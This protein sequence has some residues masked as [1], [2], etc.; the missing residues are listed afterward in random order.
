MKRVLGYVLAVMGVF[1]SCDSRK[2]W[3]ELNSPDPDLVVV[4]NGVS[5]TIRQGESRQI[6]LE[7]HL[8]RVK[9]SHAYTDTVEV[10]FK[11]SSDRGAVPL[12]KIGWNGY[13]LGR[14]EDEEDNLKIFFSEDLKPL[15][16]PAYHFFTNDSTA[17]TVCTVDS[18][19]WVEDMFIKTQWYHILVTIVGDVP[20]TPVFSYRKLDHE[21]EYNLSL[22]KS[23][24]KDGSVRKYEWC[25]DGNVIAY[26]ADRLRFEDVEGDWQSGKAAYGGTYIK[27]TTI[28]SVNH[29]FQEKG[30]HIVYY[31]CMDN[32]GAWSLWYNEKIIVE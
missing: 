26:S 12:K 5:D 28:S 22:E 23:F 7:L 30:E 3:F 16:D 2:D 18:W 4:T 11:G 24:D 6:K 29:S 17:S 1:A 15:V 25:I 32:L 13:V 19:I 14:I 9:D 8:A 20:P 27:A 31:R 21:L 10:H